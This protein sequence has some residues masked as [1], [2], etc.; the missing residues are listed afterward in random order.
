M[1]IWLLIHV[2]HA[3]VNL[4]DEVFKAD[5]KIKTGNI[6]EAEAIY[7]GLFHLFRDNEVFQEKYAELMISN[8]S[9]HE[10]VASFGK[11]SRKEMESKVQKARE[12]LS[13][14]VSND[15]RLIASLVSVSPYSKPVLKAYIKICLMDEKFEEAEK[16]IKRSKMLFPD[17]LEFVHQEMQ[18]YLLSERYDS[19]IKIMNELGYKKMAKEFQV[20]LGLYE[21]IKN[22]REPAISKYI[23]YEKLLR[24]IALVDA[25]S[26]FSPSIFTTL[27]FNV[28]FESC[29]SGVESNELVGLSSRAR[30]LHGK[31][32][33]DDTM[34]VYV[35]ALI[36]DGKLEE[37]EEKYESHSFRNLLL[38][39]YIHRKLDGAKVQRKV[40]EE[41]R[42]KERQN[43]E[44]RRQRRTGREQRGSRSRNKGDF[45]GYYNALGVSKDAKVNEIKKAYSNIVVK[46]KGK[47]KT[48]KEEEK[49]NELFKKINKARV[50][51][52][53]PKKREMYDSGIDPDNPQ[54]QFEGV[55]FDG[56]PFQDFFRGFGGFNFSRGRNSNTYFYFG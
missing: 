32:K 34:Y 42:E 55:E 21:D 16:S 8:G 43:R 35:L 31:K 41:R 18:L 33:S 3:T 20:I 10:V 2:V 38:K 50:V 30:I 46:N 49:W 11:I 27:K 5:S 12:C 9:Y 28:A 14:M 54:P 45:L 53:D 22:S 23:R 24:R 19:G 29:K 6:F 13:I 36:L 39:S 17:E 4:A 15:T 44:Y 25:D 37:A 1:L 7:R 56:D 26:N 51:L 52:I 40:E 47:K 48:K